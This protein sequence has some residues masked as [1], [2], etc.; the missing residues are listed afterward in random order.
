MR[1]RHC[2]LLV[3]SAAVPAAAQEGDRAVDQELIRLE[4]TKWDAGS[5]ASPLKLMSLFSDEMLSVEYGADVQG[6]AER[7]TWKEIL[8][9]GPLPSWK[10]Q[11]GEWRALHPSAD[12]VILSYKVTGVSVDW[13]AYAT[14]VWARRDGKWQTVFYQAS[15]AK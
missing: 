6:K 7:R 2:L 1:R 4:S 11:L 12:V 3:L 15:T 5:L 14:S 10:V 8:A 13:R 9:Y